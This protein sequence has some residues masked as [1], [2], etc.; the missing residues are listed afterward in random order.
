MISLT[1]DEHPSAG[2]QRQDGHERGAGIQPALPDGRG[3]L[4]EKE[5]QAGAFWSTCLKNRKPAGRPP[6]MR[7]TRGD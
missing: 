4:A 6:G 3:G 2:D 1:P 5:A 7:G